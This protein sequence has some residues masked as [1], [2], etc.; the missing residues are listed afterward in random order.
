MKTQ[1]EIL[2]QFKPHA[3]AFWI[4]TINQLKADYQDYKTQDDFQNETFADMLDYGFLCMG[5]DHEHYADMSFDNY[6]SLVFDEQQ[7][8]QLVDDYADI[9]DTDYTNLKQHIFGLYC[10][11]N[12]Q[13]IANGETV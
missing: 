12:I 4:A 5:S 11:P 2:E 1:Q 6:F 3:T 7:L 10:M 8:Q 9:P 13:A